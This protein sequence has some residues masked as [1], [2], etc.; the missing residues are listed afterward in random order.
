MK[1]CF[2]V[3]IF[4]FVCHH[5]TFAQSKNRV[6]LNF[7]I[8]TDT[9]VVPKYKMKA[10]GKTSTFFQMPYGSYRIMN[11][12]NAKMLAGRVIQKI[13]LVYTDYPQD[14]DMIG[15]NQKRLAALYLLLPDA[16]NN[17]LI[18]WKLVKQTKCKNANEAS[19]L[20][21][22]FVITY[23]PQA[24][25]KDEIAYIKS[26]IK[27]SETTQD[28]VIMKVLDRNK[29]WKN[30]LIVADVTGSM[31]PYLASLMLWLNIN[32]QTKPYQ[33]FV[34]FNDDDSNSTTQKLAFDKTG[35]W[36]IQTESFDKIVEVLA[37]AMVK[38]E[39]T[40][41]DLEAIF[42]GLK[43]Y[44]NSDEII[45][46][47]DHW[48]SPCDMI[49]LK[50]LKDLKKPIRVILCGIQGNVN[51]DYLEIARATGG[52]FHTIEDDLVASVLSSVGKTI[53]ILGKSYRV[54]ADRI[55]ALD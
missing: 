36:D 20:F 9:V 53:S 2:L 3:F 14:A 10:L 37:T 32:I 39:H 50:E 21:H 33:K 17:P 19:A 52:S 11:P 42:Y 51:M 34:F 28:S 38:G 29:D 4:L 7:T 30:A 18:E 41:N 31:S 55:E 16:F 1:K 43:K 15:M 23:R 49:L 13:E 27:G 25:S 24:S 40:E 48:E 6:G 44:P 22:G 47:A 26:V 35:I 54:F 45:L 46:I 5:L 12:E 8:E